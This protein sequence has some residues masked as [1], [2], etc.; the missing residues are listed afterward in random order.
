MPKSA[1]R[2]FWIAGGL[3]VV[4]ALVLIPASLLALAAHLGQV[5]PGDWSNPVPDGYSRNLAIGLGIGVVLVIAGAVLQFAAWLAALVNLDRLD[6][7]TWYDSLLLAGVL[8]IFLTPVFGLGTLL[9]AVAMIGYLVG[10]P[11]AID[12]VRAARLLQKG[13]IRRWAGWGLVA[14]VGGGLFAL[15][16]A[17]ASGSGRPLHGAVWTALA[18]ESAGVTVAWLG[19][20]LAAAAWWGAIFNTDRLRDRSWFRRLVWS[21]IVSVVGS[22]LFGI[23]PLLGLGVMVSF[24]RSGVDGLEPSARAAQPPAAAASAPT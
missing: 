3:V 15:L 21:G 24:L 19:V 12:H 6:D 2:G 1:V 5:S 20:L 8:A 17:Y 7:R 10:G 9:S 13:E 11:D 18:L 23:G 14:I 16:V 4:P 22:P